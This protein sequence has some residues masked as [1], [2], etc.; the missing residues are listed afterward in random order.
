[1]STVLVVPD[2]MVLIEYTWFENYPWHDHP[3]LSASDVTLVFGRAVMEELD[4]HKNRSPREGV[5]KVSRK[6]LARLHEISLSE[7]QRVQIK[8]GLSAMLDPSDY[9]GASNDE[10]FVALARK[11]R[12]VLISGDYTPRILANIMG[13]LN[14]EPISAERVRHPED[15]EAEALQK[16][17]DEYKKRR[18]SLVLRNEIDKPSFS[19]VKPPLDPQAF[20]AEVRAKFVD[21]LPTKQSTS[22]AWMGSPYG[23]SST[24][25][26]RKSAFISTSLAA[27]RKKTTNVHFPSLLAPSFASNLGT[28][29]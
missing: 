2:T 9:D 20:A 18:P 1:M 12:A 17:L 7:G 25:K 4:T 29:A 27:A 11:H 15:D 23:Q 24:T 5:K 22:A 14:C 3:E 16:E 21:Q 6:V 8:A 28:T 13:V 10:K 26:K 19:V